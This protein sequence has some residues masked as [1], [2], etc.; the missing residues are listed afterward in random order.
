KVPT[1]VKR[2]AS[3][4]K[5]PE[6]SFLSFMG[7]NLMTLKIFAFLP[8]RRWKKKGLPLAKNNKKVTKKNIGKRI[9]NPMNAMLKPRK[10]SMIVI[11]ITYYLRIL[12]PPFSRPY[13]NVFFDCRMHIIY[14]INFR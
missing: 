3:G 4:S 12:I 7:L 6:A 8:G 11:Y 13:C 10:G 5:F 2:S 9:I 14:I 1:V